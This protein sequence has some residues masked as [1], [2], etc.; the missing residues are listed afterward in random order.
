MQRDEAILKFHH[1]NQIELL[2]IRSLSRIFPYE[3]LAVEMIAS[4][5]LPAHKLAWSASKSLLKK[6]AHFRMA[7]AFARLPLHQYGD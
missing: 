5:T 4:I 6:S 3:R 7:A 2:P 1:L